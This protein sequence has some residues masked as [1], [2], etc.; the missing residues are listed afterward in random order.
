MRILV[1]GGAGFI[2]SHVVDA[3]IRHGHAVSVVDDESSGRMDQ[4]HP[5]ATCTRLDI[6]DISQLHRYF[7][8][9]TFDVLNHHAAQ[10]DVRRSIA[11]PAFDARVNI[12]GTLNLLEE[13][14]L[15]GVKKIIFASSGGTIYGECSRPATE[16]CAEAPESPYGVAKLA[17]ERY[18]RAYRVLH[19]LR[20][21]IFRYANVYG[22]RQDPHGEA[23]V[24]A[25]FIRALLTGQPAVIYGSGRQTRDFVFASDVA[26]ANVLALERGDDSILNIGTG[27]ETSISDLYR[28]AASLLGVTS[29]PLTQPQRAGELTRSVL[30]GSRARKVLGWRPRYAL[31]EGLGETI[32]HISSNRM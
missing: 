24:V 3:Y 16:R 2:G 23:G 19:G 10:I 13:C 26:D 8:E 14:R 28:E 30:S 29:E 31:R 4:V 32:A 25:I 11:E 5:E 22:P 15:N 9:K 7:K 27:R 6:S 12:L 1:T 21:T 17:A 20:F 18:I